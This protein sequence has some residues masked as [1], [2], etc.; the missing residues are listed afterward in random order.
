M[1]SG[2]GIKIKSKHVIPALADIYNNYGNPECQLSDNGP[3]FNSSAINK[4]C[5]SRNIKTEKI[6]PLH[7]STNPVETF[8][9]EICWKNGENR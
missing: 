2:F 6:P 4:F 7:P 3:P 5:V 9:H 8:I 1:G